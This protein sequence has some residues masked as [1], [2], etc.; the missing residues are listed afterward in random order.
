M[1]AWPADRDGSGH[2]EYDA[3]SL[4]IDDVWTDFWCLLDGRC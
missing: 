3:S 1:H 2:R 4:F